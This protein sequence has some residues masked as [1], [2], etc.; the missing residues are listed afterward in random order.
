[1]NLNIGQFCRAVLCRIEGC[2]DPY[3]GR[4]NP[5]YHLG[6]LGFY[7]FYIML[8]TGTYLFIYYESTV[9]GSYDQLQFLT[10]QQW[11]FGGV[12]RSLHRYAADAMVLV[13]TLHL[14]REMVL[15]RFRRARLYSWISGATLVPMVFLS[16]IIGFWLVWDKL[17]QFTAVRTAEW[18]DWLPIFAAP[19]ARNFL[20]NSD[21]TDLFFR[22]LI[23]MHIGLPLFLLVCMLLHIK[24]A[25]K[26]TTMPPRSL[27]IG[28]LVALLLL[29]LVYPAVSH[30]RA[31]L[32]TTVTTLDLDWF[33]YFLYPLM[34]T[35]SMG[36]VWFLFTA[37]MLFLFLLPWLSPGRDEP[38]AI[39]N[40]DHCSG[41]GFC[42]DDCPYEAIGMRSRSS[43]HPQFQD[44]A[45]VID[46]NCVQCGI[47]TGSCPSSNPFR[48]A[49]A[50]PFGH[51]E[52]L[53]SGIE[54]P[55]HT[56]D[57][58]RRRVDQALAAAEQPLLLFGCDHGADCEKFSFKN[59]ATVKLPCIGMLP[60]AFI[61]YA[62]RKGASGVLL[63]GCREG[64]CYYR[65][66]DRWLRMR[67]NHQRSPMLHRNVD[68][69]RIAVCWAS[70]AEADRLQ[71]QL[72][73][74]QKQVGIASTANNT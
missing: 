26:A 34:E 45:Y 9:A 74:L 11:Y 59:V 36:A 57:D 37:F 64:D 14:I 39:V 69:S 23:V 44:E 41:C 6:T 68:Q 58:L 27:A 66:G 35:W 60:P 31:D 38:A 29:S 12:M 2:L 53:K 61:E 56:S 52:A 40:L 51:M 43:P 21:V 17:G 71:E 73:R 15:G 33:Y 30:D 8:A 7:F 5:F 1:M 67:L 54:M 50:L 28:T 47:C 49:T 24:K 20:L 3:F 13:M 22:L 70:P 19:M 32:A 65:Y 10:Q 62:L 46:A 25:S 48:H 42:A 72:S 18:L 4:L 16:G 63:A 55:H